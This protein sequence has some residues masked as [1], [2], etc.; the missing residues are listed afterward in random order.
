MAYKTDRKRKT[1][2]D[3]SCP[4][5]MMNIRGP[6]DIEEKAY[7][8][9][10]ACERCQGYV[11]EMHARAVNGTH[12]ILCLALRLRESDPEFHRLVVEAYNKL[13][14]AIPKHLDERYCW[15]QP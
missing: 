14:A 8:H 5:Y 6:G 9:R 13:N 12:D 11:E 4:V 10:T 2:C 1:L 7:R 3:P 15:R